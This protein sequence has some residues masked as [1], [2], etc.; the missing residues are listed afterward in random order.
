MK[1]SK[2][3]T[4]FKISLIAVCALISTG[5]AT[6]I[7]SGTEHVKAQTTPAVATLRNTAMPVSDDTRGTA[8]YSDTLSAKLKSEP[9][10]KRSAKPWV[11]N[12]VV[13]I[14]S[15]SVLPSIFNEKFGVNFDDKSKGGRVSIA[16]VAERLTRITGVPVRVKADVYGADAAK[17]ASTPVSRPAPAPFAAMPTPLGSPL[18]GVGLP[19]GQNAQVQ[20]PLPDYA[21]PITDVNSVEMAWNGSLR[22]FLDHVTGLLNLS[23]SYREGTVVIEKF[24]TETF[25][26]AAFGGTQDYKMSISGSSSGSGS[27]GS[28]NAGMDVN[29]SGKLAAMESLKSAITSILVGTGGSVVLNEASG[30]FTV[31]APRDVLSRVRQIVKAEDSSLQRQAHIQFDIYSVTSKNSEEVGVDW[32]GVINNLAGTMGTTI[33][34]P[35]TIVGSAAGKLGYTLLKKIPGESTQAELDRAAKYGGSTGLVQMLNQMGNSAQYRPVSMIALNRQWARKTSLKT[36][37][38]VSETTPSTSSS[39]GSG[40]PGLKTASV[41]T[42]DKFLVQPAILDNGAIILKFG[43]SLTDLLGLFNVSAGSGSS[44]QTVQTPETSGTDDQGTVKLMP[45]EQMVITGLSR[46]VATSDRNGFSED[47]PV[48]LG[49]SKKSGYRREDFMI[50]VRATQL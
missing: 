12:R 3:S 29:E 34:T 21:Q 19:I 33:S 24:V 44:L 38:Y 10:A 2:L 49:G 46:R 23:W 14:Q 9:V 45:G 22:G 27:F 31:S 4:P 20:Q 17:A 1:F 15:D 5:C 11:G 32:S 7:T 26:V 43:V 47:I 25:E 41:T 28:A 35:T 30:R 8:G 36:T 40:A 39:A 37:G 50:V 48:I 18:G 42:G 13:D 16:V 6:K